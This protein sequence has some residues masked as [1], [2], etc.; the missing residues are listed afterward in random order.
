M[1]AFLLWHSCG[2]VHVGAF[3]GWLGGAGWVGIGRGWPLL[4]AVV[5]LR[6]ASA[7]M[8]AWDEH[9]RWIREM[10]QEY[11]RRLMAAKTSS[12]DAGSGTGA[13]TATGYEEVLDD[14]VHVYRS[15]DPGVLT[16]GAADGLQPVLQPDCRRSL[17]QCATHAEVDEEWKLRYPPMLRRQ[18]AFGP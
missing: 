5:V 1:F 6:P 7:A 15:I 8:T 3:A 17:T 10:N 2:R 11:A 14:E 9:T 4:E 12:V 18:A 13:S 16:G